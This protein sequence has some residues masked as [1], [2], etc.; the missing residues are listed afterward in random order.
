MLQEIQGYNESRESRIWNPHHGSGLGGEGEVPRGV[1]E[2]DR[3]HPFEMDFFTEAFLARRL[4]AAEKLLQFARESFVIGAVALR[5]LAVGFHFSGKIA[6][7]GLGL[8]AMLAV[9]V[10][11]VCPQ[12]KKNAYG[13]EGDL[14][15]QV[16]E[17]SSMFS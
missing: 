6:Q 10:P 13:D 12:G 8:R 15:K 11:V 5:G 7:G 4:F 17:T 16:D 3:T 14:E 9:F 1:L 2:D